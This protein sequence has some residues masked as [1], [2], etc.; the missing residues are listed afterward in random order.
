[1]A[2]IRVTL[3]DIDLTVLSCVT[4]CTLACILIGTI[5]AFSSILAWCTGTFVDVYL[6]EMTR[7]TFWAFTMKRVDLV[8]AF[9]AVETRLTGTFICVN[10]AE[11]T[12]ISW[13]T[14]TVEASDLIQT[15]CIIK[16]GIRHALIDIH[17]TAW[18]FV[19]LKTFALER[20]FGVQ[21]STTMFTRVGSQSALINVLVAGGP[22]VARWTGANSLAIY[23]VGVTVGALLAGV[24]DAGVIEMAQQTCASMRALAEE[25]GHAVMAGSSMIARC[26]GAVIDVLAAV[27]TRPA[28][29]TD[30]VVTS[31]SVMAGPSV[32]TRVGHQLTFVHIFCAIL[33]CVMRRALA[34]VG[35][36]SVHTDST[37]L[38]VVAR[39]VVDVVFTVWTGKAWQ[40][41]A[42]VGGVPLLDAGASVLAG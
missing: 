34:V 42:V 26:T 2:G 37:V 14:N 15:G 23:W 41:A 20:A 4:F 10:V 25:G 11:Y 1:M 21:T 18:P 29:H 35:V 17:L 19:S 3:V 22:R 38:A 36:H 32:L 16:A 24:T 12:L 28:V 31:V 27:V 39:A 8:N 33:T 40:A 6:A 9:A 7:K 13:H 30:A 5:S